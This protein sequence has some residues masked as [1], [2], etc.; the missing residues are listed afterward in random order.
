M[1]IVLI[2]AIRF[3]QHC[4]DVLLGAGADVVGIV[5]VTPVTSGRHSDFCDL[6]PTAHAHGIP[7]VQTDRISAPET[8]ETIRRMRP[9]ILFVFGFSQLL[10]AN[11]LGI[12]PLGCVGSHPSLLPRN[13]GRH[14]LI[15]ALVEGLTE[16]G[17]TFFYLDEGADSGDILWQ[18]SFPITLE[19]DAASL[20]D[21]I[22]QLASQGILEFQPAL[23]EGTAPRIPQDHA[24]ATY[25]R[26]R[27]EQDGEIDWS[28]SA[29]QAYNLVRALTR[30]YVG[31]HTWFQG[32]RLIVWRASA[33]IDAD[34]S[35]AASGTVARTGREG[36]W[37]QTGAGMLVLREV[38]TEAGSP[39]DL[40]PGDRLVGS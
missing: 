19:D 24:R 17:L 1:R 21:K 7:L 15:W 12:A 23:A 5:T 14:P 18:R 33:P 16:S 31:A 11:L 35:P 3:S 26:K 32:E 10:P 9:D 20:Y 30:P 27:T 36:A 13:R 34:S 25:W 37:V 2:G 39:V 29:M 28:G 22:E 4:L 38:R 8:I 6:A 40:Q